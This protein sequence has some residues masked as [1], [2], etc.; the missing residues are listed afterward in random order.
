MYT[1]FSAI[2]SD[3]SSNAPDGA[4]KETF[5]GGSAT[6]DATSLRDWPEVITR[7]CLLYVTR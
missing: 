1:S 5:A 7:N 4:T 3:A 2:D 6:T